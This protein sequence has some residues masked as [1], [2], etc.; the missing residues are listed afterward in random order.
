MEQL[1]YLIRA[2]TYKRSCLELE[3]K[4]QSSFREEQINTL[5]IIEGLSIAIT[6]IY[7]LIAE[8]DTDS[9]AMFNS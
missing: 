6:E 8:S 4:E 5:G 3:G 1:E 2:L 9:S 7:K